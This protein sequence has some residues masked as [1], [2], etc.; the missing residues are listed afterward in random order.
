MV[1][2]TM[3]AAFLGKPRRRLPGAA[4]RRGGALRTFRMTLEYD[5]TGYHG[6]QTQPHGNTVQDVIE[7]HLARILNHPV[8]VCG[9]G[10]T[11]RGVHARGQVASFRTDN[12]IDVGR[13][14]RGMNALLPPQIVVL[15]CVLA[16]DTFH[17]RHSARLREYC[18]Q[19]WRGRVCSPFR[20][21]FV[22]HVYAE[23]NRE[24]MEKAAARV[25]GRHDFTSFCAAISAEG[26]MEKDVTRSEWKVSGELWTY[27]IAARSFVHHMV[28]NLV[29]TFLEVGQ[30]RRKAEDFD[31]IIAARH[32]SSA[33][34]MAPA[35]GLFLENVEF[36]EP[37][38]TTGDMR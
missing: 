18:Y 14:F 34:A 30:G 19:I 16:E 12:P 37:G 38:L 9:S 7:R 6:W 31:R 13:V 27:H 35:K 3:R 33:G 10:R 23:L 25:I 4:N 36:D 22:H 28:R 15:E 11:D 32:R 24:E 8:R 1:D 17:A 2:V 29:G 20:Y 21:P 26:K 5:G